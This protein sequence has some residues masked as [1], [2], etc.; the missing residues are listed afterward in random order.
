VDDHV[1][2]VQNVQENRRE[3]GAPDFVYYVAQTCNTK[4]LN[5]THDQGCIWGSGV[6][7]DRSIAK[8]KAVGEA[9]ERYC[10][11]NYLTEEF[12]LAS[13]ESAPFPCVQP[14]EFALFSTKQHSQPG[15][16]YVP[17]GRQSNVR[18]VPAFDL[19]TK[20]TRYVPAAMVFLPY[21]CKKDGGEQAFTPQISTGLACHTNATLAA[22]SGICE[23]IERDAFA[24]TWQARLVRPKIRLET[25]SP[26]N[27]DLLARLRRPG[28]TVILL[29]LGMDHE[30][31]VIL[32]AMTSTVPD[33]PALVVAAAAHLDPEQAVQ[34]SLEELAQLASFAQTVKSTRPRF[35]PGARWER[36]VDPTSHAAVYF[37]H[38]NTH[39]ADFLFTSRA[40]IDF[41][42]I[43]NISTQNPTSDLRLL[44]EKVH[45][46]KHRV[47]VADV[48]TEDVRSLGLVVLRALIP[49]FHPLYMGHRF[50]ALGG[51]RLWEVPQKLGYSAI[52]RVRSDNPFPHPFS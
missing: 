6:S 52:S 39:L 48:T 34:K 4:A 31:P 12:P 51:T 19:H 32:S 21:V 24:I 30:I 10:A 37:D 50:R 35:S 20:E 45:A 36:V 38:A 28:A 47:L 43:K 3:A 18:W 42:E 16:P 44:V 5:P 17:F 41:G 27:A 2:I 7:T 26:R 9:I 15:F 14:E 29:Y 40:Q 8:A 33:A 1:G 25:L 13:S 23:V 49:G 22:F 11:A 46:V